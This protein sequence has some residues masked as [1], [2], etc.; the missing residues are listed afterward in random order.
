MEKPWERGWVAKSYV[1]RLDANA[2]PIILESVFPGVASDLVTLVSHPNNL[3]AAVYCYRSVNKARPQFEIF[4]Q[5]PH[6]RLL[7]S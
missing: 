1:Q 5:R 7:S 2:S 4:R 6:S 3:E